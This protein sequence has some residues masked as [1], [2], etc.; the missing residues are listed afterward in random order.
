MIATIVLPT[1]KRIKRA[2]EDFKIG[3]KIKSEGVKERMLLYGLI[4]GGVEIIIKNPVPAKPIVVGALIYYGI[5][6]E[7][8]MRWYEKYGED[9]EIME[10]LRNYNY[11]AVLCGRQMFL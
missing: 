6:Y 8:L 1:P 3:E 2:I 11:S 4:A 7:V 5:S 10:L 9:E